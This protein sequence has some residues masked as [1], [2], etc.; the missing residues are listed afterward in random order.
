MP[1]AP[2]P[3]WVLGGAKDEALGEN[4]TALGPCGVA[5][6]VERKGGAGAKHLSVGFATSTSST[7]ALD[8]ACGHAGFMGVD[9]LLSDDWP[10]AAPKSK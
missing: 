8:D 3:T 10:R 5:T 6:V 7:A 1:A 4:V 2:V 9:V